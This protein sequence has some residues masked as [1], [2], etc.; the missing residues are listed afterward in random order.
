MHQINLGWAYRQY[1]VFLHLN[2]T[3]DRQIGLHPVNIYKKERQN[4]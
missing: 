3:T 1:Y 4:A 2:F